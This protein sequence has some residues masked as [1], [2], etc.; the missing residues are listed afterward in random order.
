MK[1]AWPILP[2]AILVGTALFGAL[3]TVKVGEPDTG[4]P[5]L[6]TWEEAGLQAQLRSTRGKIKLVGARET[7]EEPEY[8]GTTIRDYLVKSVSVQVVELPSADLLPKI[9]GGESLDFRLRKKGRRAHVFRKGR[10]I[11]LISTH[12]RAMGI[13]GPVPEEFVI[14]TIVAFEEAATP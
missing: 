10:L 3:A 1:K 11:L 8:K 7:L 6:K 2:A 14:R 9:P 13:T 12:T 5:W 4:D